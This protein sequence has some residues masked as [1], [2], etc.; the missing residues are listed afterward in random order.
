MRQPPHAQVVVVGASIAGLLTAR[1]LSDH[2]DDIVVLEREH[3]PDEPAPRAHVPQGRHLHLLLTAGLDRLRGWFPGIEEELLDL[4]AV[5]VD[6]H[7]AYVFQGGAYR[8]RGDWG[9]A[10]VSATRPLL[11]HVVRRRV[12]DLPGVTIETGV[13]VERAAVTE[14]EDDPEDPD[15]ADPEL[16]V[17]GVVALGQTRTADLVV[18]CSGR[19]S[20]VAHALEEEGVLVPPVERV[21]IDIGYSSCLL[22]RS[23][24]DFEGLLVFVQ[25]PVTF[26]GGAVVPVEGPRWQV[27]LVGVHGDPPPADDEGMREFARTLPSP[28]AVELLERCERVSDIEIHRFPSS[29]RRRYD[30]AHRLPAGLVTLGDAACSF[31][32]VYGQGM[33]SAALQAEALAEV[34][35]RLG[36]H[37]PDLPRQFHRRAAAVVDA[38]WRIAVGADFGH[39]STTGPRPFATRQL[40]AYVRHV[41]R[42]GH[43]SV[44]VARAF[45]RVLQLSDPPSALMRPRFVARVARYSRQSPAATGAPVAHPRVG[46]VGG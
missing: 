1:A 44:D 23:G 28:V 36:L 30:K 24:D 34:V 21:G 5:H 31:N 37:A 43:V 35:G 13:R 33:T 40:N 22:R 10:A 19:A 45:N 12:A 4:G 32:P 41:M 6:G 39:P 8:A 16:R 7:G 27:T 14:A 17:T 9:R 25:D 38:P 42:A 29:Q 46:P 2:V 26:R 15:G 18:D 20:R 3:P 11:E